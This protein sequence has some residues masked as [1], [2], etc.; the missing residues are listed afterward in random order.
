MESRPAVERRQFAGAAL[1]ELTK[2]S[3][4]EPLRAAFD[5]VSKVE[6]R[7]GRLVLMKA[8]AEVA[9]EWTEL[10]PAGPTALAD[11]AK[12][13]PEDQARHLW[14]TCKLSGSG[15]VSEAEA[16]K[17]DGIALAAALTAANKLGKSEDERDLLAFFLR[18]SPVETGDH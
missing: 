9:P 5:Q 12:L 1:A 16:A 11:M 17:T 13:R 14:V 8:L 7:M 6:P 4:P 3:L 2:G 15:L 18:A 10:C